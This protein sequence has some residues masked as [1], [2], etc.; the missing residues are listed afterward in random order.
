MALEIERKYLVKNDDWKKEN[1]TK[2]LGFIWQSYLINVPQLTVRYRYYSAL[3]KGTITVKG[4]KILLS[5]Q[6]FEMEI[7]NEE[8]N[9]LMMHETSDAQSV[10]KSRTVVEFQNQHFEIDEFGG[11]NFGLVVAEIELPSVDTDVILPDWIGKE[12][13]FDKKYLNCNLVVNPFTRW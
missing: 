13:T 7:D 9:K 1:I 10:I 11:S 6:E 5:S 3:K 12:I 2:R 8:I 4:E